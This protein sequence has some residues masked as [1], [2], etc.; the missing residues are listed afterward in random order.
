MD[1]VE[2]FRAIACYQSEPRAEPHEVA[3]G[4]GIFDWNLIGGAAR[5]LADALTLRRSQAELQRGA[6]E[7]S[8]KLRN[9]V[10]ANAAGLDVEGL[11]DLLERL[12]QVRVEDFD[13]RSRWRGF[14]DARRAL[15]RARK[16]R[17]SATAQPPMPETFGGEPRNALSGG[18]MST[19]S[20]FGDQPR[21]RRCAYRN[22]ACA[23]AANS[24]AS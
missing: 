15:R 20:G 11:N 22:C 10:R 14:D 16:R 23:H 24:A 5:K 18:W 13:A 9:E 21:G 12:L 2:I 8:R 3:D 19:S 7:R 1:D 6:S 4:P 17:G